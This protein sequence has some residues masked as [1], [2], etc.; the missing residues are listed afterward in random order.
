[1]KLYEVAIYIES[2]KNKTKHTIF[3]K[4]NFFQIIEFNMSFCTVFD[5]DFKSE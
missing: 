2:E 5:A 1:M 4:N 3:T